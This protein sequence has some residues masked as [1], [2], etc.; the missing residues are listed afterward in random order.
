MSDAAIPAQ[1]PVDVNVGRHYRLLSPGE[2]IKRGDQ[3]LHDDCETWS[4]VSAIVLRCDYNPM[5]FVPHR[6]PTPNVKA[7]RPGKARDDL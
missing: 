1:G 2:R 5:V 7:N 4:D 3:C 6:R